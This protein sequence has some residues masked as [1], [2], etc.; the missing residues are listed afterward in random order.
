MP[1]LVVMVMPVLIVVGATLNRLR[2]LNE[3]E[4][5]VRASVGVLVDLASVPMQSRCARTVHA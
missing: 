4:M 2:A 1:V 5:P 3:P